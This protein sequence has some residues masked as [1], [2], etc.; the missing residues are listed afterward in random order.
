MYKK[1][2]CLLHTCTNVQMFICTY[3][4]YKNGCVYMYVHMYIQK[5]AV[6]TCTYVQKTAVL[7]CT[8]VQKQL[9]L[10]VHTYVQSGALH[11]QRQVPRS[12]RFQ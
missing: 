9:C 4:M 10:H 12:R 5:T 6:L 2:L 3:S 1:Q 7:T 11:Q 8:Y